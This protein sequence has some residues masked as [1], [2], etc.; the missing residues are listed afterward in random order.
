MGSCLGG[1]DSGLG[2]DLEERK[3][4][5]MEDVAMKNECLLAGL[6]QRGVGW[7]ESRYQSALAQRGKGL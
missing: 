2:A 6:D 4:E 3:E 1:K 5:G 7:T